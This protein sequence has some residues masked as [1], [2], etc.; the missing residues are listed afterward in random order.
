[1]G[2]AVSMRGLPRIEDHTTTSGTHLPVRHLAL[3][4]ETPRLPG[5]QAALAEV[6]T[7]ALHSAAIPTWLARRLSEAARVSAQFIYGHT[8]AAR[9]R[10]LI[11]A[12]DIGITVAVTDYDD[13]PVAGR[14]AWL[15]VTRTNILQQDGIRP[16]T[17]PLTRHT[18]DDGLRLHRTPDGHIRL[19]CHAPWYTTAGT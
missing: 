11:T 18:P 19:G 13:L 15:D 4:Y 1:M 14:P 2:R 12:D 8:N 10:L 16:G 7:A 5:S 6:A 9:Y 17:D 3:S